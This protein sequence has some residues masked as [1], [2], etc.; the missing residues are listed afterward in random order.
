MGCGRSMP[1]NGKY[2]CVQIG[3]KQID[4]SLDEEKT[5]QFASLNSCFSAIDLCRMNFR[6]ICKKK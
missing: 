5:N 2:D 6:C 4:L 3:W 1:V